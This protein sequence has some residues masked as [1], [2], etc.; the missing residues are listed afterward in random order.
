VDARDKRK[1]D[2]YI[3]ATWMLTDRRKLD[4]PR[5]ERLLAKRKICFDHAN[6]L[7]EA[8]ERVLSVPRPIP[9]IAFHLILLAL[10]E[11]GKAGLLTSR[12]ASA[13]FRDSSWIDKRLDD[14]VFKLLWGLWSPTFR[15]SAQF[16]P[17]GFLQLKKFSQRAHS[18]RLAGLYVGTVDEEDV[19]VAPRE[20]INLE[21]AN[22]LLNMAKRNLQ[23]LLEADRKC[24]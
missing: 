16:D 22:S 7:I 6:D 9:N 20:A 17:E 23:Q 11:M 15:N 8:A 18:Q 5:T 12:A 1:H 2:R 10:E 14:H 3:Q 4:K 19:D 24:Y 21:E 13:G